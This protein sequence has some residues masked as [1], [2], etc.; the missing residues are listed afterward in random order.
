[1]SDDLTEGGDGEKDLF[2]M[3]ENDEVA[4][5]EKKQ[6][7]I[8]EE[9]QEARDE[10]SR[11]IIRDNDVPIHGMSSAYIELCMLRS[12][13]LFFL[14]LKMCIASYFGLELLWFGSKGFLHLQYVPVAVS[15]ETHVIPSLS[16]LNCVLVKSPI[17]FHVHRNFS[18]SM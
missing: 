2:S 9:E 6:K 8:G 16:E 15:I 14:C 10:A 13:Q 7:P 4:E 18:G 11:E 12:F 3:L 5:E 17:S 1:M